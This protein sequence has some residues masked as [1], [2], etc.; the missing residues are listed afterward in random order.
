[1]PH[2]AAD[3]DRRKFLLK[4][5]ALATMAALPTYA[6]SHLSERELGENQQS[7]TP[8]DRN[9]HS[10][11]GETVPFRLF[12]GTPEFDGFAS[13]VE[14]RLTDRQM[15][16][17]SSLDQ[18][19]L[20]NDLEF[21]TADVEVSWKLCSDDICHKYSSIS[22]GPLGYFV[23]THLE[24]V[25]PQPGTKIRLHYVA[26]SFPYGGGEDFAGGIEYARAL[27]YGDLICSGHSGIGT[28]ELEHT[29]VTMHEYQVLQQSNLSGIERFQPGSR[30][31]SADDWF[32]LKEKVFALEVESCLRANGQPPLSVRPRGCL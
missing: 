3:S 11:T 30:F 12:I 26:A 15:K 22:S 19:R 25:H 2:F 7:R 23:E 4:G 17:I 5:S 20:T 13:W 29:T 21:V 32:Q 6:V 8:S 24:D 1:M 18:I 31:A 9:Q 10:L 16:R 14:L 28:D 27:G